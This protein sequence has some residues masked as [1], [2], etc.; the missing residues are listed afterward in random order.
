M[1]RKAS[2]ICTRIVY[3]EVQSYG[4][5]KRKSN[6]D[7]EKTPLVYKGPILQTV[8]QAIQVRKYALYTSWD[9]H[10]EETSCSAAFL[11]SQGQL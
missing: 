9:V 3:G 6:S 4:A 11:K 7:K 1:I 5:T 2:R 10:R 8:K